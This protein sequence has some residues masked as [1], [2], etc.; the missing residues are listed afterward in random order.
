MPEKVKELALP[1]GIERKLFRFPIALFHAHLGFLFGYRF[2]LL[3]HTGR[4][5]GKPR[6]TVLEIV[7]Y[8]KSD[9]SC[10]VASGWGA[11]SDWFLNVSADPK[12]KFQIQNN[13][14]DGIA[15]RL[16][17]NEAAAELVSYAQKHPG[18]WKELATFMG[19]KLDGSEKDI[20]EMGKIL[21]LFRFQRE[22]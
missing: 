22:P 1:R 4:K 14:A 21:P 17:P 19:Y 16:A 7:R 11:K 6:Q 13:E 5:S 18:A 9:G 12:I 3:T 8:E 15:V 20:E 2:V 10:I